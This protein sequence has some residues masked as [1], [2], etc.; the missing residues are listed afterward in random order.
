MTEHIPNIQS[1]HPLTPLQQGMIFHTLLAPEPGVYVVQAVLTLVGDVHAST[2]HRA[3]QSV[4]DRHEILR[5][6]FVWK[7]Q[8]KPLQIVR[9]QVVLPWTQLDWLGLSAGDQEAE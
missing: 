9:P 2:L 7:R 1:I 8:K 6:L 5:T 3:R 4:L